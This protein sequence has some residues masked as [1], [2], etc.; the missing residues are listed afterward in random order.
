MHILVMDFQRLDWALKFESLIEEN[1][2]STHKKKRD[3]FRPPTPRPAF[4]G[5]VRGNLRAVFRQ[6]IQ[7]E[8]VG[9]TQE[10][11]GEDVRVRIYSTFW[12]IW[13]VYWHY[14]EHKDLWF[15]NTRLVGFIFFHIVICQVKSLDF[16]KW[17]S[18]ST[19]IKLMP[20]LIAQSTVRQ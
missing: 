4:E 8:G 1:I 2:Y 9:G 11:E 17:F 18:C 20:K 6:Q 15:L 16:C 12:S 19:P 3:V 14:D 5:A 10:E 13:C 7:D